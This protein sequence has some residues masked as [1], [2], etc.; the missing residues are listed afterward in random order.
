MVVTG[1]SVVTWNIIWYLW[2]WVSTQYGNKSL[3]NSFSC[4][5]L[6]TKFPPFSVKYWPCTEDS[7]KYVCPFL[8]IFSFRRTW[9]WD[10]ETVSEAV[11]LWVT[12]KLQ[13]TDWGETFCQISGWEC[14]QFCPA[15]PIWW[16]DHCTG[17]GTDLIADT[18]TILSHLQYC[19]QSARMPW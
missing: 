14:C 8:L 12:T 6:D 18:K 13:F 7:S 10:I 4:R 16:P 17:A 1:Q 9:H 19:S 5:L 3:N 11:R 15:W 2:L